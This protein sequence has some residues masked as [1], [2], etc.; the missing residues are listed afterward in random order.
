[1]MPR[2]EVELFFCH[3]LERAVWHFY[4]DDRSMLLR[5]QNFYYYKRATRRHGWKLF[6][7]WDRIDKRSN[8]LQD[9]RQCGATR[10]IQALAMAKLIESISMEEPDSDLNRNQKGELI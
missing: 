5:L 4:L 3:K 6:D 8:T 10:G 2:I 9:R 1:M 7:K